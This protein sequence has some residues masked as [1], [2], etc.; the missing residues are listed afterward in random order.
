MEIMIKKIKKRDNPNAGLFATPQGTFNS[1]L[2]ILVDFNGKEISLLDLINVFAKTQESI[3]TDLSNLKAGLKEYAEAEKLND[4][5]IAKSLD[6]ISQRLLKLEN[7]GN[8]WEA[9]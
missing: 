1:P 4:T 8:I 7:V 2:D 9:K 3:K 6:T 5:A